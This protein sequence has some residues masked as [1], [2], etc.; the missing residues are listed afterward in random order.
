M[1]PW[2][3][4]VLGTFKLI[5]MLPVQSALTAASE[6]ADMGQHAPA[7][8]LVRQRVRCRGNIFAN[9]VDPGGRRDRDSDGRVG[10]D[11]F[12][13]ELGPA[14]GTDLVRPTRQRLTLK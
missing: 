6:L 5:T 2:G 3:G 9:M 13:N 4:G 11:G 14:R 8:C 7:H 10:K 12:Q 1:T